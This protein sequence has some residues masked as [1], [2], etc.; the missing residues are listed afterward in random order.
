MD[1]KI[2]FSTALRNELKILSDEII[3]YELNLKNTLDIY[4]T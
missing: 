4:G 2:S 1:D 3:W